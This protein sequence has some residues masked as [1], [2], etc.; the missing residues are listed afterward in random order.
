[1]TALPMS[2]VPPPE[3]KMVRFLADPEFVARLEG[4]VRL[5]KAHAKARKENEKAVDASYF[6]R[7]TLNKVFDAEFA[8]YGGL[9]PKNEEA[10]QA[11]EASIAAGV[12]KNSKNTKK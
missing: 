5:W 6:I 1:M 10:W 2:Y 9:L 11:I 4:V 3:N 12:S 7:T 8:E